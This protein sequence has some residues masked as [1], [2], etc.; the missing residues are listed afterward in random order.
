MEGEYKTKNK[1]PLILFLAPAYMAFAVIAVI[2][3]HL[4]TS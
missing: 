4:K 1:T 3:R 2:A